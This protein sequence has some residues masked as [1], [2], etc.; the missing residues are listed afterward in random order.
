MVRVGIHEVK[1]NLSSLIALVERNG[2]NIII[3]RYGQAVAEICPVV[4]KSRIVADPV[5]KN[6]EIKCD[7]TSP[8][9]DEWEN[10]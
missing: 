5:L 10:V 1:T 7:L 8:T 6:I 4:K 3:Q 2:E 9:Q